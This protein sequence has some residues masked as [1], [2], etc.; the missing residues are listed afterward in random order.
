MKF[1]Q[2]LTLVALVSFF[3][4]CGDT[5]P[6]SSVASKE[7][8][9]SYSLGFNV[10]TSLA[11]LELNEDES[12][13]AKITEGFLD[14]FDTDSAGVAET[15]NKLQVRM[16][17][18][19]P[20]ADKAAGEEI[21]YHFGKSIM[22]PLTSVIEIPKTDF[23]GPAFQKGLEAAMGIGEGAILIDST[24]RDSIL[25]LYMEPKQRE[26]QAVMMEKQKAM[27]AQQEAAAQVNIETGAAFLAEN[28][29]KP[30]IV[31]T[32]SGLQYEVVEPGKGAQ[33]VAEDQVK[34]HYHGTLIDGTVF[35]SSVDRG[36]PTVFGV[37]QVIQGWQEGLVLMKEGA[38]YRFYIPYDLA[39]GTNPAGPKIP[40]GS[41][42]IFDVELIE[43]NPEPE[44]PAEPA[45]TE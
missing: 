44:T 17:G 45:P 40:G 5:D 3:A 22:G 9:R 28:K 23:D 38:K 34:V 24:G 6:A 13:S 25:Q 16:S 21:A 20:S 12:N 42:L 41:T 15:M 10:G 4:A 39:Y 27:M 31:T 11:K 30:G 14:G 26:Y 43:I 36:E 7:A 32:E 35:D 2:L 1:T 29:E 37:G 19:T 18:Q 33:P 8:A